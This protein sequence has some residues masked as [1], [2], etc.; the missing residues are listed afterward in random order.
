[1]GIRRRIPDSLIQDSDGKFQGVGKCTDQS[2]F[3][4]MLDISI[5]SASLELP[6][7]ILRQGIR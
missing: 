2:D 6:V 5:P 3:C 7:E 4:R 1:M